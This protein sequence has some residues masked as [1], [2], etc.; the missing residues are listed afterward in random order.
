MSYGRLSARNGNNNG[1]GWQSIVKLVRLSG[2]PLALVPKR[3]RANFGNHFPQSI[4]NVPSV[5]PT[6]G[7]LIRVFC[8]PN[9]TARSA[10]KA[11]R[12]TISNVAHEALA[13]ERRWPKHMRWITTGVMAL[14][15]YIVSKMATYS[16][17]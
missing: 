11:D 2:W 7:K 5:T 12:P 17:R 10:K 6:F 13:C 15:L 1:Y 9:A 8:P 3:R 4:V 16:A 14:A